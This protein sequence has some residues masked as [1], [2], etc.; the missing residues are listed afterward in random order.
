M[1][2]TGVLALPE[3]AVWSA[4]IQRCTNPKDKGYKNYGARGI[5]ICPSWRASFQAFYADMGARPSP[6]H[7]IERVDNNG[8][9]S[10]ENCVW[11]T[12]NQQN[13]N[14]RSCIAL[15][16]GGRTQ[17][18]VD[19][20]RERGMSPFLIYRRLHRGWSAWR[21]VMTPAKQ[22]DAPVHVSL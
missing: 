3:Y 5:V 11:G 19:W 16:I 22:S 1:P 15:T 9:Y 20:A 17:L 14:R 4:M 8:P 18:V 13:R 7:S 21:A 10:P 6:L 12:R 2:R